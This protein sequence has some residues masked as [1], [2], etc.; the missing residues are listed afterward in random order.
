MKKLLLLLVIGMVSITVHAQT[1][2]LGVHATDT[3][4]ENFY[5]SYRKTSPTS[6]I[7]DIG[8]NIE[9]T[10]KTNSDGQVITDLLYNIK[11]SS[12][13]NLLSMRDYYL[14]HE[15]TVEKSVYEKSF[16]IMCRYSNGSTM[17]ISARWDFNNFGDFFLYSYTIHYQI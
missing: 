7:G 9:A 10:I 6:Y 13:E 4:L 16:A 3:W 2:Y 1:N 5:Q 17:I 12:L 14:R 15:Y 11:N 8:N